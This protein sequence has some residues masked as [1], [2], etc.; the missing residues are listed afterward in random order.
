M[1]A[2][3]IAPIV[4]PRPLSLLRG[5]AAAAALA[6]GL[7]I[8][9]APVA[10]AAPVEVTRQ[11][12]PS[13]PTPPA[14][15]EPPVASVPGE[16]GDVTE[17]DETSEAAQEQA[18]ADLRAVWTVVIALGVVA[19]GLLALLVI[20]VRATNP[21]R[22]A[23]R[24]EARRAEAEGREPRSADA[25]VATA[26]GGEDDSDGTPGGT[27]T[28]TRTPV[29]TSAR[30]AT[31]RTKADGP[32]TRRTNVG[33]GSARNGVDDPEGGRTDAAVVRPAKSTAT[34]VS[35]PDGDE[36]DRAEGTAGAA[37]GH[38]GRSED[39]AD[40]ALR[41]EASDDEHSIDEAPDDDGSEVGS[42]ETATVDASDGPA[43]PEPSV[44]D[45]GP[46]VI[47]AD[48]PRR[49]RRVDAPAKKLGTPDAERV[50]VRPGQPS[51]RV[52]AAPAPSTDEETGPASE[53]DAGRRS[54][55]D[56]PPPSAPSASG[57]SNGR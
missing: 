32:G 33:D 1:A 38:E 55:T 19:L 21:R 9:G 23:E 27:A 7:S 3:S 52:P 22:S 47:D 44:A 20:Y 10:L 12:D 2:D 16:G 11:A 4:S 18:D 56:G 45:G 50:L 43:P 15:D 13:E 42:D 37:N 40:E 35:E 41:D 48:P 28:T 39:S 36:G 51:I 6:I 17:A 26:R 53:G 25:R 30:P 57:R 31:D 49:P 14:G 34:D 8:A 5:G 54:T 24:L 46:P 29:T